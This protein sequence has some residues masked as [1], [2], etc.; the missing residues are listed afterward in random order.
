MDDSPFMPL[1]EEF[2]T[3]LRPGDGFI[4]GYPRSGTRWLRW[5]LTDLVLQHLGVDPAALYVGT[6]IGCHPLPL[7]DD[8]TSMDAQSIVVNAHQS[9]PEKSAMPSLGLPRLFRSHHVD[10]ILAAGHPAVCQFRWP[11]ALL[12]SYYH[13]AVDL[14]HLPPGVSLDGFCRW[15]VGCWKRHAEA[16]LAA[17]E[18][19]AA[20]LILLRYGDDAPLEAWQ[21]ARGARHLGIPGGQREIDGALGRLKVHLSHLNGNNPPFHRGANSGA[22]VQLEPE[23]LDWVLAETGP[24]FR[25]LC[26]RAE[27]PGGTL[28]L[29]S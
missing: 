3:G 7:G 14:G 6:S 24:L 5:I 17:V 21:A 9:T 15:Q 28:D 27:G 25:S 8:G 2:L 13:Y 23:L 22:E 4:L 12:V 16:V 26:G 19:S 1:P 11:P 29:A 10:R 18:R 20:S